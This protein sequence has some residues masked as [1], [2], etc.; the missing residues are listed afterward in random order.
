MINKS[1]FWDKFLNYFISPV[2]STVATPVNNVEFIYDQG[3]QRRYPGPDANHPY[4][5]INDSPSAAFIKGGI[6]TLGFMSVIGAII[7]K[8]YQRLR[9]KEMHS[10]YFFFERLPDIKEWLKRRPESECSPEILLAAAYYSNPD[11]PPVV[12]WWR[13]SWASLTRSSDYVALKKYLQAKST[14]GKETKNNLKE[15]YQQINEN[16]ALYIS[17]KKEYDQW[18]AK[19]KDGKWIVR[20]KASPTSI[21]GSNESSP[22]PSKAEKNKTIGQKVWNFIDERINELALASFAYWIGVFIFYL[23]AGVGVIGVVVW[24]PILI[25]GVVLAGLWITKVIQHQKKSV[26]NSHHLIHEDDDTRLLEEIKHQLLIESL[27]QQKVNFKNSKL[28]NDIGKTLQKRQRMIFV[29]CIFN[30]FIGGFFKISFSSWLIFA[31]LGLVVTLNPLGL[32]IVAVATLVLSIAYGIY[33]AMK[34]YK[35]QISLLELKNKQLTVLKENDAEIP[36]IS[37]REYDRLFR[38]GK[39]DNSIWSTTKQL[40]KRAWVGLIRLGTG[41]LFLKLTGFGVTTAILGVLGI[42]AGIAALPLIGIL[43]AGG[44]IFAGWHIYQYHLESQ[45][46]QLDHVMN[47]LSSPLFN[48]K[49]PAANA[50]VYPSEA[51]REQQQKDN[52]IFLFTAKPE[53]GVRQNVKPRF[54]A[55]KPKDSSKKP[56]SATFFKQG[57]GQKR[58]VPPFNPKNENKK[59]RI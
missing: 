25:A 19:E 59:M 2:D 26:L 37:L 45:E 10:H 56:M 5:N 21:A 30:G 58:E 54:R 44:L 20:R 13:R 48:Q 43:L 15:I 18:E 7:I 38:R 39:P 47:S 14:I 46:R 53:I 9:K 12:L 22:R 41:I 23:L 3:N 29:G 57:K 34:N 42:T 49:I 55:S 4:P 36:D 27:S 32:A 35:S 8:F 40:L 17:E 52:D 11:L 6:A 24:P 16:F 51:S 50:N 31:A 33:S 28:Y 1:N